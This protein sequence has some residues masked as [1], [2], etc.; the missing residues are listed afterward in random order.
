MIDRFDW[1]RALAAVEDQLAYLRSQ[2][3]QLDSG[4]AA[5]KSLRQQRIAEAKRILGDL[6]RKVSP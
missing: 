1:D 5:E 6:L 2:R 3:K 4:T